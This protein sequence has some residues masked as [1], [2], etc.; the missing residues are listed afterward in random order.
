ME[1]TIIKTPKTTK[2]ILIIEPDKRLSDG[3]C[4]ALK[5]N[6]MSFFQ[7]DNTVSAK[8]HIA[9]ESAD[10][11]ILDISLPDGSAFPF[12]LDIKTQTDISV[13]L[14]A[15]NNRQ[16]DIDYG[17]QI[18]A[19]D[20][21]KKPVSLGELRSKVSTQLKKKALTPSETIHVGD[22]IF[23]FDNGQFFKHNHAIDLSKTEQRLLRILVENRGSII[24]RAELMGKAWQEGEDAIDEN[25]L[26]VTIKRL[27]DKLEEQPSKPQYIKSV[28]GMGYV[29]ST[30]LA[31]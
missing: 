5:G 7:C 19:E 1:D 10:L 9:R 3:I 28:Y 31:K 15:D 17:M 20:C 24:S 4:L 18:G 21:L 13:I 23:S 27:R 30:D 26:Y 29:W 14:L 25:T 2:K 8:E 16:E 6:S 12:L 11:I 22:Y